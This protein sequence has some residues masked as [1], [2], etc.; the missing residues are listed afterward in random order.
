MDFPI[1]QHAVDIRVT[2]SPPSDAGLSPPLASRQESADLHFQIIAHLAEGTTG[3]AD[4]EAVNPTGH[5]C[6]D[7]GNNYRHGGGAPALDDVPYLAF[8]TF[9]AFFF[10]VI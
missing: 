2:P 3:V 7:A 9:R 5:D 10:G 6:V 1:P 8:T 4:P